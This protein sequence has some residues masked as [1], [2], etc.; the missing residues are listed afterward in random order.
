MEKSGCGDCR[1]AIRHRLLLLGRRFH[2]IE[3]FLVISPARE[4]MS[5]DLMSVHQANL[6]ISTERDDLS[7][8]FGRSTNN[9]VDIM[10]HRTHSCVL[11]DRSGWDMRE[12]RGH[13]RELQT[14][15]SLAPPAR[16]LIL[17]FGVQTL[18]QKPTG[19]ADVL[20]GRDS[21]NLAIPPGHIVAV[22]LG[23]EA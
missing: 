22:P 9:E 6:V 10:I 23:C 20:E 2:P 5:R 14:R 12:G 3:I 11:R 4:M 17:L 1:L 7:P 13:P 18:E 8:M 19:F 16:N 21:S 15:L